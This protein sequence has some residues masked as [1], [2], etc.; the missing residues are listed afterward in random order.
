MKIHEILRENEEK[1]LTDQ[2]RV[3]G[4]G[5]TYNGDIDC[6][7]LGLTSLK[8]A[9]DRVTGYFYCGSNRLTTL[10]GGPTYV[11]RDFYCADNR[12]TSLKGG[13]IKV[14]HA[15]NCGRNELTSLTGVPAEIPHD[16]ICDSNELTSLDGAPRRVGG[17]F[18][19]NMNPII[20]LA[21]I[22]AYFKNGWIAR[23]LT[24][25]ECVESHV[26]G[27]LLIPNLKEVDSYDATDKLER[28]ISIINKHL[29]DDRDILECQEDL[30]TAGLREY[31]RL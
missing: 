29:R 14:G 31:G 28:A 19:C 27:I 20:S 1:D 3:N 6:E 22:G 12:L 15:Y 18:V 10:V 16:F 26:L 9:P 11:G 5:D 4:W 8:G 13:P 17:D 2:K 24:I 30:R 23:T 7:E 25:P 21:G